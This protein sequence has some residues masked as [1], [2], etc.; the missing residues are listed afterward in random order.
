LIQ[1]IK[2]LCIRI[3]SN[4]LPKVSW[5]NRQESLKAISFVFF[6][7][8]QF[9]VGSGDHS[10]NCDDN[11]LSVYGFVVMVVFTKYESIVFWDIQLLVFVAN[12]YTKITKKSRQIFPLISI[13]YKKIFC[14]AN[15]QSEKSAL[16]F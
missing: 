4:I 6:Q 2:Q 9:G 14:Q 11:D 16:G 5:E 7:N 10:T 12:I 1:R 13:S 15:C 3:L 8:F